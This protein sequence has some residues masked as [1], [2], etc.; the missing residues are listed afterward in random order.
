MANR[1]TIRI[2]GQSYTMLADE[3]E[4]YMKEVA[5][6]AQ[7]T[8]IDCG[9]SD[10]FAST[11]AMALALVNLADEYMKAKKLAEAAVIKYRSLEAENVSLRSKVNR[12]N[13]PAN[14]RK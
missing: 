2:A 10:S 4:E 12:A 9:G 11:R 3:S 5:V 14:K 8:L 1:V 13:H 6:L 7:K